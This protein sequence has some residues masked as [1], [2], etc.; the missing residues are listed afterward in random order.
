MEDAVLLL[1]SMTD[2][3]QGRL[4]D[5]NSVIPGMPEVQYWVSAVMHRIVM[6]ILTQ[7]L[8][9]W[10]YHLIASHLQRRSAQ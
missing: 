10:L 9:Q 7:N 3:H 5:E 2:K 4:G 1:F 6:T 8:K